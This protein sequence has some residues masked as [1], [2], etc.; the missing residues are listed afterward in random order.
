MKK[1]IFSLLAVALLATSCEDKNTYTISGKIDAKDS[2]KVYLKAP[3]F[4]RKVQPTTLDSTIVKNGTFEFKGIAA[5]PSF[6]FILIDQQ[7]MTPKYIG[8]VLE[9]GKLNVDL[10]SMIISG[11]KF[12]DSYQVYIN[13]VKTLDKQIESI[14]A[15][16]S[17]IDQNDKEAI[18]KLENEYDNLKSK[19]SDEA[20]SFVK[21][22]ADNPAGITTFIYE[23]SG[24]DTEDTKDILGM[25]NAE[26]KD[27]API[28]KIEKRISALDNTAEGKPYTDLK[29]KNQDG[30]EIALSDYVGGNNKLVLVDFWASWC[31]PCR[32]DMPEVV[33][34]YK[35][36]KSK[37][38]EIVG[39]SLDTDIE[40]WKSAL[41]TMNM[42]WPQMSDL[43]GWESDLAGSYAVNSIPHTVLIDK[44]GKIIAKDLRSEDLAKKVSEILK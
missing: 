39:V 6:N 8:I 16:A 19:K 27:L 2:T 33:E 23:S 38:L 15:K 24:F 22:N 41:I 12:N 7:T 44:D 37:G 30:K 17:I 29:S 32:K 43:K 1:L 34:L 42:T 21:A 9:P 25:L 18:D 14:L 28:K 26:S 31:P 4:D 11:T 13:K 36:Y 40:A 35:K 5:K 20:L 3:S 10:D